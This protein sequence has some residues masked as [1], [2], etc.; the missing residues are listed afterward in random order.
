VKQAQT[1]LVQTEKLAGLAR[2]CG[3][4]HEINNPLSFVA[5]TWLCCSA[6]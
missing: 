5:K 1:A 4:A 3:R 2:W 6:T